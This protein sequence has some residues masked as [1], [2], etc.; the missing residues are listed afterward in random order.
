MADVDKLPDK[1][2]VRAKKAAPKKAEP[3][4]ESDEGLQQ[5]L[6]DIMADP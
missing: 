4:A 3:K 1:A 5:Q 6:D 2:S